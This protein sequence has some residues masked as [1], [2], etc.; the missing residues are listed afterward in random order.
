[1]LRYETEAHADPAELWALLARPDRWHEW[2]PHLRG[3]WGL[4]GVDGEVAPGRAGAVKLLA[5]VPVPV[6][7]TAKD[8][9]RAWSWRVGAVV[10]MDHRIEGGRTVAIEIRAPRPLE[11][12]LAATYGPLVA[13]LLARLSRSATARPRPTGTGTPAG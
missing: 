11:V 8:P 5:V 3:A 9:G 6:R 1:M 10:D 12:T 13:R 2:A 4:A 7:I